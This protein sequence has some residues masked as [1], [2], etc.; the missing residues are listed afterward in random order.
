ME[1]ASTMTTKTKKTTTNAAVVA[2]I[3]TKRTTG[4]FPRSLRRARWKKTTEMTAKIARSGRPADL[5]T[6]GLVPAK[7]PMPTLTANAS[8]IARSATEEERRK[9]PTTTMTLERGRRP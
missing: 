9:T 5:P 1:G 3:A 8:A 6:I 2:A 4:P 7:A